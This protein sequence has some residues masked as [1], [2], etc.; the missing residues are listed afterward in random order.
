MNVAFL[1]IFSFRLTI[2]NGRPAH[3]DTDSDSLIKLR[4]CGCRRYSLC[5]VLNLNITIKKRNTL[6]KRKE[7][8]NFC[9]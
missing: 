1:K 9:T 2:Q 5:D 4:G 7:E 3:T 8:A 6:K